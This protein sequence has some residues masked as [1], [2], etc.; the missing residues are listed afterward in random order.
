MA[1]YI[2]T[3]IHPSIIFSPPPPHFKGTFANFPQSYFIMISP[4][5]VYEK[6]EK[7]TPSPVSSYP[8]TF[9]TKE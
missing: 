6:L 8:T 5:P 3:N 4:P 7:Y 9:K 1:L 2:E